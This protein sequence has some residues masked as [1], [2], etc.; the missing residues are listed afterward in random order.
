MRTHLRGQIGAGGTSAPAHLLPS[1]RPVQ[2]GRRRSNTAA[3][4]GAVSRSDQFTG[5]LLIGTEGRVGAVPGQPIRV[6]VRIGSR[7]QRPVRGPSLLDAGAPI[8]RRAQQG[9]TEPDRRPDRDQVGVDGGVGA[10]IQC[11]MPSKRSPKAGFLGSSDGGN[12]T[13][14]KPS[15][16]NCSAGQCRSTESD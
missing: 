15:S 8:H 5:H 16:A 6:E 3:R 1:D 12:S 10:Q 11:L 14:G 9:M 7:G 13:I 2:E 4:L